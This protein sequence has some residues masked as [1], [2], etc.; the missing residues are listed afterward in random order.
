MEEFIGEF[1][2]IFLL[3]LI[4]GLFALAEIALVSANKIRL[5]QLII[6]GD[7]R[8]KIA[9]DL[10]NNPNQILSTVQIG[11]TLIGIFAGAFGGANIA[12]KIAIFLNKIP[13]LANYGEAISLSIV[14]IMITYISLVIGELVPKRLALS[15]PEIIACNL[16]SFL[17]ILAKIVAPI[18]H[19]L[20][21]ST[22]LILHFLGIE[23]PVN[24]NLVT[25]DEIKIMIK[26]GTEA[27]MFDIAEQDML[28][29]VLE[30]NERK[31]SNLMTAR[32]EI[33]W[34]NLED[35]T[36]INRE[37]IIKSNHTRFPVS[38]GSL[39]EVLG[40]ANVTDL[41]SGCLSGQDFELTFCLHQPLFVPESTPGLKM[42]EIFKQTGHHLALVVDEYGVVQGLL[43]IND[44]LEAIIGDFPGP[45]SRNNN[46]IRQRED[47]SWLV[48]GVVLVDD[49][50]EVLNIEELPWEKKG[51][52][53]TIGGFVITN[54]GKIPIPT[55]H[56]EW[57]NYRFEVMD[58]DGNRVN[59]ILVTP[60][61]K[62]QMFKQN[63]TTN[64]N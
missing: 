62:A 40:I 37:K 49:F 47:G 35:S 58:M 61:N 15:A 32:P 30:L 38:Q 39:E 55:D 17:I 51:N 31:V 25:S 6:K 63:F 9:L 44:I 24:E 41:L 50:K 28:E 29:K 16:A 20:S 22:E 45:E 34:L 12:Q 8:A 53:H 19:L 57:Q 64:H 56:F 60:L 54:L 18:V 48:D 52:Y 7:Y 33:V 14:V 26:Q 1:I 2:I 21:V 5:E 59:K 43:T 3:I 36:N 4:N 46:P 27:G 23:S 42:L 13:L 11:I 10:A